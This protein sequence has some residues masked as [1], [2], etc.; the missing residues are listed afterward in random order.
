MVKHHSCNHH[1]PEAHSNLKQMTPLDI[2]EMI[3]DWHA[4][5]QENDMGAD[6]TYKWAGVNIGRWKFSELQLNFIYE[7]IGELGRRNG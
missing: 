7:T 3:C 6:S 1:H 5:S 4:I 2:V